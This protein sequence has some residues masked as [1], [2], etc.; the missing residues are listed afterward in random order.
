MKRFNKLAT[1]LLIIILSACNGDISDDEYFTEIDEQNNTYNPNNGV[2][3]ENF[4]EPRPHA[5]S[6][7]FVDVHKVSVVD[8][9]TGDSL[10]TYTFDEYEKVHQVWNLANGDIVALVGYEDSSAREARL[11]RLE[12]DF[13]DV[14]ADF[15]FLTTAERD[16]RFVV[17]DENLNILTSTAHASYMNSG[18]VKYYNAQ[19]FA[20]D[21]VSRSEEELGPWDLWRINLLTSESEVMLEDFNPL[22][23]LGFID[24]KTAI[25]NGGGEMTQVFRGTLNVT[26][27]EKESFGID[28]FNIR[29]FASNGTKWLATE[30]N[31]RWFGG[32]I[33][34]Q[35]FV[36]NAENM[37]GEL[38]QLIEED[39][40][41]AR[42]TPDGNFIVAFDQ[43]ELIFRKYDL[44]GNV[45][46][47][48]AVEPPENFNTFEIFPLTNEKHLLSTQI[49][50]GVRH[51]QIINLP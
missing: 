28:E 24:D 43:L 15:D 3:A 26:T 32:E 27:G 2:L 39:S 20:Y 6:N 47:E 30:S 33:T 31:T 7:F 9:T 38:V 42:L 22:S 13:S 25:V 49:L 35:V 1:L 44:S 45:I 19:V 23:I 37:T 16:F 18:F 4:L 17:F 12:N 21:W 11:R 10:N 5:F 48:I 34:S 41:W 46:S 8:L 29:N 51:F 36:L 14:G 40:Y 50:D